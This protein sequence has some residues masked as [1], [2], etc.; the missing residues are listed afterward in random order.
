MAPQDTDN[1][2][3]TSPSSDSRPAAARP[4]TAKPFYIVGIGASAGGLEALESFFDNMPLGTDCAF[5]I[6]QHLSP[7]YKSL[8]PELLNRH[9]QFKIQQ[10]EEG[11]RVEP[12]HIYLNHPKKNLIIFN[13]TLF[14]APKEDG[15]NLPIDI[16]LR[17][18]AD[19]QG[20]KAIGI[21]LSGTGTDGTRGIRAIKEAGGMVMV[22]DEES[23]QFDGMPR[24]AVSTGIVDYV[25]PPGRMPDEL[26]SFI[27]GRYSLASRGG[28]Q[29][30]GSEDS[31]AKIL[32]M[33]RTRTGIDF[34]FYKPNTIIRRIERRMGINQI[35][36]A[37][38]Y[39]RFMEEGPNEVQTLFREIL[40]GV[41][42][43]FREPEA[44]EALKQKVLPEI[45]RDRPASE[46]VR[47]WVAG[48]STGEEAYSLAVIF[49]EYCEE[50]GLRHD[51]K[52]FSTD[53]DKDA[54]DF[55]S[56]GV[57]P[58][59]I[60]ADISMERLARYFT[61]KGDS[62]QIK[63]RIRE[64]VIFAYHNILKDPPFAR[65]DLISCR[66]LLIY[67]QTPLQKRV[68]NNF[69]FSLN[70][71]GFL[72][73]GSSETVGDS[74][75]FFR[76]ID[77]KW[78]LLQNQGGHARMDAARTMTDAHEAMRR[79]DH[80]RPAVAAPVSKEQRAGDS[81]LEDVIAACLAPAVLVDENRRVQHIFGDVSKVL[82]LPK[83]RMNTDITQMAVKD[84]SI[85]L[86]TGLQRAMKNM[87][88]VVYRNIGV[89]GKNGESSVF[90]MAIRPVAEHEP[91]RFIVLFE[92]GGAAESEEKGQAVEYDLEEHAQ[93]RIQ[94]LEQELQ[95]T[96][97]NLQ[98]TVEEVETSNE[99][100][101]ATNE[102]LLAANEE[103]QSTNEELQSVNEELLTVNAEYQKKI[104]ELTEL[105]DDMDNLMA[106][107]GIGTLFIDADLCVRKFT[108]PAARVFHLI[109]S[110][111]GR[112][113]A[114]ISN[115]LEYEDFHKDVETVLRTS[116]KKEAE[117][118]S[119]DGSW[120]LVRIMPYR[121][122]SKEVTG[123]LVSFID[124]TDRHLAQQQAQNHHEELLKLLE[125]S[126]AATI[127][128]G[129]DGNI[130]FVNEEAVRLI[131]LDREKLTGLDIFDAGLGM[132]DA[133]G[134]ALAPEK[135]PFEMIRQSREPLSGQTV[136][137]HP[138]ASPVLVSVSG[139]PVI[140]Q[141]GRFEGAVFKFEQLARD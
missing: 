29:A 120:Y 89:H 88:E 11:M 90:H 53:I 21:I 32:G 51:I 48:C 85:P 6:V 86:A 62:Y 76:S 19:D 141:R 35:E 70:P 2:S 16:F 79:L 47:I 129:K 135:N 60:V 38:E 77:V 93:K 20:E 106:S 40:I 119:K 49:D 92:E 94:D 134:A 39:I 101:Q 33:I 111:I 13:G 112:P 43:F 114:H 127:M 8:M 24:S 133:N 9:T 30:L 57:Y 136:E 46:P 104:A 65:T 73:L 125:T 95:Y 23:A 44:F 99:E 87:E 139:K 105:N 103:L 96:K 118:R 84:L 68:L 58:E 81:V 140:S 64:R 78:R 63:S 80:Q 83:G 75:S 66:N 54:L 1:K 50:N 110:D 71:N 22:Q 67:L 56:Y 12:G 82:H 126:P 122:G 117:V 97:E 116:Q 41:T 130:R 17:S 102:E 18:L 36:T 108:Q 55:A 28:Q 34:S 91:A 113:I 5:V 61:K 26:K 3:N 124:I 98:A 107:T 59:S 52:I 31:V 74:S 27:A 100:L 37:E 69:K 25:L 123:V 109:K 15:L 45:F 4:D 121:T 72:F 128:V 42:K 7:D 137:L 138:N 115:E 14:F 10:A 132:T 131:G